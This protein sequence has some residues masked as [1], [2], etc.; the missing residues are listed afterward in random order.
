VAQRLLVAVGEGRLDLNEYDERVQRAYSAKTYVELAPLTADLP[1]PVP[2]PLPGPFPRA[3]LRRNAS[4][5]P[6][7]PVL[8]MAL[9]LALAAGFTGSFLLI[10]LVVWALVNVSRRRGARY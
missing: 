7:L 6:V 5:P 8:I 2:P 3:G 10:G 4:V 1:R 9:V